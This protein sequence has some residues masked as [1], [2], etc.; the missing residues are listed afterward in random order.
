METFEIADTEMGFKKNHR[1]RSTN[2]DKTKRS[3]T[4]SVFDQVLGQVFVFGHVFRYV[5][6]LVF[7]FVRVR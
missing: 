1:H 7:V 5:L 6:R 4:Y 2:Q 3:I